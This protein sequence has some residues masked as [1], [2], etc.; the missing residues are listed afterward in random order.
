MYFPK[1]RTIPLSFWGVTKKKHLSN[2][3]VNS[4]V[5]CWPHYI[6]GMRNGE[7]ISRE[8]DFPSLNE[9]ADPA[10]YVSWLLIDILTNA[11]SL[12]GF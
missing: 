4:I 7:S 5:R 6:Q 3:A 8:Q 1:C 2:I 11:A 12:S 10:A 9:C